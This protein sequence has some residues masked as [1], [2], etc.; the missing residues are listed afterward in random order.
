MA[1]V[2]AF[3]GAASADFFF[4]GTEGD[5][6][7]TGGVGDVI[8]GEQTTV[9]GTQF[10]PYG[11]ETVEGTFSA[12]LGDPDLDGAFSGTFDL[13]GADPGDVLTIVAEGTTD[14]GF[15][16]TFFSYAGTWEVTGATGAYAG[17]TGAGDLSGS[18]FFDGKD[19]GFV[20]FQVQGVLV[21]TPA[22]FGL[23]AV[24]GLAAFRRRR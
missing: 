4:V 3:A 8:E 6:I 20:S 16:E 12:E 18:N 2:G 15:D 24:A 1:A 17:L 7:V 22:G 21:P 11:F 14:N 10:G 9:V 5:F 13:I 19:A 23:V